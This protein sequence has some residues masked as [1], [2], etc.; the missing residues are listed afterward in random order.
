MTE[1]PLIEKTVPA[2]RVM[3][4][5][6]PLKFSNIERENRLKRKQ[7]RINDSRAYQH[8]HDGRRLKNG[9][10]KK[11]LF[12]FNGFVFSFFTVKEN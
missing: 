8:L 3:L 7:S 4:S 2:T 6:L 11:W 9:K 10:I 5:M 1:I 12:L